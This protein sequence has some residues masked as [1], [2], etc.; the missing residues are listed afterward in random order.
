MNGT[1]NL[2]LGTGTNSEALSLAHSA[3]FL[4]AKG[5]IVVKGVA[6][7]GGGTNRGVE[8][9]I[10]VH[11]PERLARQ[12]IEVIIPLDQTEHTGNW[13]DAACVRTSTIGEAIQLC[14][15]LGIGSEI[16]NLI[17]TARERDAASGRPQAFYEAVHRNPKARLPMSDAT[18]C[19]LELAS[20]ADSILIGVAKLIGQVAT[21]DEFLNAFIAG[22]E[23]T[24]AAASAAASVIAVTD[25]KVA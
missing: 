4:S 20:L 21:Q 8:V 17:Q 25:T 18:V 9:L 13:D 6:S 7:R 10:E 16:K 1:T 22:S 14:S 24:N 23:A 5:T 12:A 3:G 2:L 15:R 11:A 19:K